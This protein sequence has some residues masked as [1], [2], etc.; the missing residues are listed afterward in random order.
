MIAPKE[1]LPASHELTTFFMNRS[2]TSRMLLLGLPVLAAALFLIF[3]ATGSGIEYIVN[4]ANARN[5]QLQTQAMNLAMGQVL[6]ET[7]NQ[8]LILAAGSMN[9]REMLDRMRFRVKTG[10]LHYRELAF[11]GLAPENSFL[12][13]NV[14]DDVVHV[15][16]Q[17]AMASPTGPFHAASAEKLLPGQVNVSQ[18]MEALYSMVPVQGTA[19]NITVYVLRFTTPVFDNKNVFSGY[20]MLSLDLR[21]L[22]DLISFY[23]AP[24][25]P[26]QT[27]SDTEVRAMFFDREGWL[28]FQSEPVNDY[29]H[30]RKLS[31]DTARAGLTGIFGRPGFNTAF[32]PGPE[33]IDYWDMVVNVQNGRSGQLPYH[34]QGWGDAQPVERVSYVPLRFTPAA[35]STPV[36]LGGLAVLDAGFSTTRYGMVLM[37]IYVA[38]FVGG[39]LL[40]GLS[41]WWLARQLGKS[42][43]VISAELE[44]RNTENK[45]LPLSLPPLPLE[46]EQLKE[47]INILL[48]RLDNANERKLR[49]MAEED[50]HHQREPLE[51]LPMLSDLPPDG[52]VGFSPA[53][54]ILLENV[55]K[56]AQVTDDVLVVGETGTGKELISEAIHKQSPRAAAPFITINC[57]A[58]DENLLMD[59]LFGHVKG[60][61]TEARSARKGAFLAA[62]GGTLMLDEVGNAAPKVQQALLR[63]L[64]TRRIRPLGSDHDVP[65]DTRI[66][67]ATNA[68]LL[69]DAQRGSFRQ[70]LYY[71]LAVITINS[72]PL[73]E[74]KADIP[75]LT[76]YFLHAIWQTKSHALKNA[77][78]PPKISHGAMEKL[79]Q[80]DWP[81]NVREL[82]NTLARALAFCDGPILFAEDIQL[83]TLPPRQ[84]ITRSQLS[85]AGEIIKT[86]I[87]AHPKHFHRST[88]KNQSA[89]TDNDSSRVVAHV[90]DASPSQ[91]SA[92]RKDAGDTPIQQTKALSPMEDLPTR[93]QAAWPKILEKGSI[94]RQEYQ[95]F[96]GTNISNRTAQYDLQLLEQHGL[97]YKEGYGR[98]L[99]YIV[100][101][102]R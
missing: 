19:Q 43:H 86:T 24:D 70:D 66:I 72:P 85:T 7:R 67:A 98:S 13:L 31:T 22:R 12:L 54:R 97:V 8:L 55:H 14:D 20:L 45:C 59:T 37:G 58:L 83:G 57:G 18:P 52:L 34:Q 1:N 10:G 25:A 4:R 51:N 81:G 48:S 53:M 33:H 74:R 65:F 75:A 73:R 82:K 101:T 64:S 88:R 61:F 44:V 15:P 35:G 30:Q 76:V 91:P 80:Y 102:P 95:A 38:A 77:D 29:L 17:Q 36:L 71:R 16:L 63:A 87:P 96:S 100:F 6:E 21:E 78:L 90:T 99:R 68:P 3:L 94:T 92:R 49:Q 39:M 26:M 27:G 32:R 62:E 46:L 11:E 42:L 84:D 69:E 56:A 47:G 50:A 2:L 5:I 40:L 93:V 89:P 79:L 28:L 23:S 41:L 9:A 60:A